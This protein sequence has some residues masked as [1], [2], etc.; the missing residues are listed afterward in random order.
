MIEVIKDITQI[1]FN[2]CATT[3]FVGGMVIALREH[4]KTLSAQRKK[5]IGEA[6]EKKLRQMRE[7]DPED[8]NEPWK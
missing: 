5:E 4:K 8:W 2:V 7:D 1:L 6:V 3:V